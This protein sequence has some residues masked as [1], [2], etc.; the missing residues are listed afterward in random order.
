MGG[1]RQ[2]DHDLYCGKERSLLHDNAIRGLVPLRPFQIPLW[3]HGVLS[4]P[5]VGGGTLFHAFALF[6][7]TAM[8]G[9]FP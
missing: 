8:R 4:V 9:P 2:P 6:R 3:S 7:W 1:K 5:P